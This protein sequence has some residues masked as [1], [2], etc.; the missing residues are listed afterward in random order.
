MSESPLNILLGLAGVAVAGGVIY[1]AAKP[2]G[3]GPVVK[4]VK[5]VKPSK[6]ESTA[7]L[8]PV[9]PG[10][11]TAPEAHAPA[12]APSEVAKPAEVAKPGGSTA[13][14]PPVVPGVGTA[15]A[16]PGISAE[17]FNN[18]PPEPTEEPGEAP[19]SAPAKSAGKA[20]G[21]KAKGS[22]AKGGGSGGGDFGLTAAAEKAAASGESGGS[23]ISSLF[24]GS[25]SDEP[26]TPAAPATQ[27]QTICPPRT[28]SR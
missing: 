11:G 9:V 13:H 12:I 5:S 23:S 16:D 15:S 17:D 28:T 26:A 4:P 1:Y 2:A 18:M 14:L 6:P 25:G 27:S 22:K 10:V 24:F 19:A 7:H 8:P 21:G 3:V 20:K